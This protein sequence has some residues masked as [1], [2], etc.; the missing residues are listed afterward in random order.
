MLVCIKTKQI[1]ICVFLLLFFCLL[2]SQLQISLIYNHVNTCGELS[3]RDLSL[4]LTLLQ[5]SQLIR[6][7]DRF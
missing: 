4:R 5:G 6:M 1:K 2:L 3:V 7:D